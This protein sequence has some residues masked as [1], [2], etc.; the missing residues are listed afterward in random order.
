MILFFR[1]EA[2]A[3]IALLSRP[4]YFSSALY[5]VL[6]GSSNSLVKLYFPAF[7]FSF[8]HASLKNK[9]L[10]KMVTQPFVL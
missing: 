6:S 8:Y 9:Y 5:P 2:N 4:W 3:P 7:V 10:K 1:N